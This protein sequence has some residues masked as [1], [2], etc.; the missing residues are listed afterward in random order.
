MALPETNQISPAQQGAH[1]SPPRQVLV[2]GRDLIG[3]LQGA[4]H[5]FRQDDGGKILYNLRVSS[6]GNGTGAHLYIRIGSMNGSG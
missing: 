1:S 6:H 5:Q 4:Y 2:A 3:K